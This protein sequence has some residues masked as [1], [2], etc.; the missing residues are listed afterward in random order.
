MAYLLLYVDD[1]ILIASSY[2]LRGLF[3][4]QRKYALEII[5]RAGMASCKPS[6]TPVDTKPKMSAHARTPY[7][8]LSHYRS[9]VGALHYLTFTRPD[10]AYAVQQVCLFMHDPCEEHMHALKRIVR[11]LQGTLDHGLH[12]YPSSTTTLTSYTDADWGGCLDTRRSTLG[13]CV[14]LGDNL[15]SWSAKRQP[16]L[17]RSSVEAEYRGVANVVSESCWLHNFLLELHCPIPKATLVYCDNVSAIYLSGNAANHQRTKHIKLDI[18]FVWE[19]VARGQVRVLH[20]PFGHQLAD[21]FTKGLP[22]VLFKDFLDNLSVR[23]SPDS[24]AGVC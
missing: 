4:S 10:I 21:I 5:D 7:E 3:L 13:Y 19:K 12:L 20:V 16:T 22:L 17:S 24:I 18:H 11:Y 15:V 8:D 14:F 2:T 6:P 1:I 23:R 9:L